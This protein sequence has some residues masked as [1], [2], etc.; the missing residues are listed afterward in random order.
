MHQ[1]T[2]TLIVSAL[3]ILVLVLAILKIAE[4]GWKYSSLEVGIGVVLIIGVIIGLL[5]A[6][7]I[8]ELSSRVNENVVLL[9]PMGFL[10]SAFW[11]LPPSFGNL[12]TGETLGT[13][14]GIATIIGLA[15]SFAV[16]VE[17]RQSLAAQ[18]ELL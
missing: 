17:I 15:I 5:H 14:F 3:Y 4:D 18:G 7:R 6:F 1:K 2:K 9:I 12:N 16:L 13:V 10:L 8:L 11:F